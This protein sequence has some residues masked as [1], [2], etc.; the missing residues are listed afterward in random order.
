MVAAWPPSQRTEGRRDGDVIMMVAIMVT[1]D[2]GSDGAG[3]TM[4]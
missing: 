1:R 3:E 2:G 4:A